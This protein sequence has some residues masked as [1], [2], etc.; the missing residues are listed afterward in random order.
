MSRCFYIDKRVLFLWIYRKI[1]CLKMHSKRC[2]K[3]KINGFVVTTWLFVSPKLRN[4]ILLKMIDFPIYF[5]FMRQ[6]QLISSMTTELM[7]RWTA[8]TLL[9]LIIPFGY[10]DNYITLEMFLLFKHSLHTTPSV[11]IV[12]QEKYVILEWLF[13]RLEQ[14]LY[15]SQN[16]LKY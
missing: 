15:S 4:K 3:F 14:S 6:N 16:G 10:Y 8:F 1:D 5:I 2:R 7:L 12:H 13:F 11:R 9:A